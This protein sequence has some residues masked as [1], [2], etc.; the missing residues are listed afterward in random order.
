MKQEKIL[1]ESIKRLLKVNNQNRRN[2]W[3]HIAEQKKWADL[4]TEP[5]LFPFYL[6]FLF[7][8]KGLSLRMCVF[9]L[10][11]AFGFQDNSYLLL[12]KKL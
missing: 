6:S 7:F 9:L 8:L 5:D 11:Q 4:L 12:T 3:R 2:L 10:A 1:P